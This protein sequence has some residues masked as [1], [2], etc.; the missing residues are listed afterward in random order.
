MFRTCKVIPLAVFAAAV[1]SGAAPAALA[2]K[3]PVFI[4]TFR[5]EHGT[6]TAPSGE[7][8]ATLD[9]ATDVLTYK[10]SWKGLSGPVNAA[11]FHGPASFDQDADVMVPID[12][13]YKSPLS[14]KVT[15]D[16]E[17]A[18]QLSH[19]QVYVNL[20]TEAFPNG[21]ARAQMVRH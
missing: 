9:P 14:G 3:N 16:S 8:R 12:G 11:H 1:I 10:I 5:A 18:D 15:L 7:V 17:Q 21:E 19:G 4:G 2:A 20:H 13:P 6:K